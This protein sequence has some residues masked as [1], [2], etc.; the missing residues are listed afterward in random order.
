MSIGKGFVKHFFKG[1]VLH[2]CKQCGK[3]TWHSHIEYKEVI[4]IVNR[5][6]KGTS[7]WY[8]RR[9]RSGRN[10]PTCI[11]RGNEYYLNRF[12]VNRCQDCGRQINIPGWP[13]KIS[14]KKAKESGIEMVPNL[15]FW[16]SMYR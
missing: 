4:Q 9:G 6:G 13:K 8:K 15:A 16:M 1:D 2:E 10:K 3:K 5:S 7:G 14:E 12:S 11:L